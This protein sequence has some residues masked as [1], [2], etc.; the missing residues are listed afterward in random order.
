MKN[1]NESN[2]RPFGLWRS[3]STKCAAAAPKTY[4]WFASYYV[5]FLVN[6]TYCRRFVPPKG[7][8]PTYQT[9]RCHNPGDHNEGIMF[10]KKVLIFGIPIPQ[11]LREG[12]GA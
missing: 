3:A 12:G 6:V 11:E 4:V 10:E 8:I 9:V 1:S 5:H 2:L 7:F